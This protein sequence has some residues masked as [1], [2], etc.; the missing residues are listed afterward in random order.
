[1]KA[2]ATLSSLSLL[3]AACTYGPPEDHVSVENVAVKPDASLAAAIVKYER[4]RP[5][6]GLA[7]FPDG[8]VPA[9]LIQRADVYIVA[10]PSGKIRVRESVAAPPVHELAFSPWLIG[11][12]GDTLYLSITG[13]PGRPGGECYGPRVRTSTYSISPA[14][15]L[16]PDRAPSRPVLR[17]ALDADG[18]YLSVAAER[19]GVSVTRQRGGSRT[20][21][22]Q[23]TGVEL[24][25]SS[26][27][28]EGQ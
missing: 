25:A 11:W 18:G 1:V 13:C 4:Y 26:N 15:R 17:S 19:Y 22:L 24:R 2:A 7:A 3:L 27:A 12:E 5:A 8:G 10:L 14:G 23:F 16:A 6:A 21:L 28:S 9:M 20:P